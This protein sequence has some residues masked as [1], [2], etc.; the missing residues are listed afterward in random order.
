[1]M[2]V[3]LVRS[4]HLAFAFI[5]ATIPL[6]SLVAQNS[7]RIEIL[8]IDRFQSIKIFWQQTH[9]GDRG[10]V[11]TIPD[12][13]R[14]WVRPVYVGTDVQPSNVHTWFM[15][16]QFRRDTGIRRSFVIRIPAAHGT[17][18]NPRQWHRLRD[19]SQSAIRYSD[20][21]GY[22]LIFGHI[23]SICSD[24]GEPV[25][26]GVAARAVSNIYIEW[27]RRVE[28]SRQDFDFRYTPPSRCG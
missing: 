7:V 9:I 3:L 6:S 17:C 28:M 26:C 4:S 21:F 18:P 14:Q 13:E 22:A 1:M 12:S 23:A 27:R 11:I 19:A 20:V 25:M 5:S 2:N 16:D 24:G 8:P 15:S 10:N